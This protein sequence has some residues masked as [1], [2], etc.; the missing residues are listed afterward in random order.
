MYLLVPLQTG[1][2]RE[3]C[4]W[5]ASEV[6]L[7]ESVHEAILMSQQHRGKYFINLTIASRFEKPS[8]RVGVLVNFCLKASLR[9]CAGSVEMIKTFS[10]QKL[11]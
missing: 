8:T 2:K 9:L 7:A 3:S 5:F 11:V 10:L 4:H 6:I 1:L